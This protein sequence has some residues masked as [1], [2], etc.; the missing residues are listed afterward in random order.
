MTTKI[1]AMSDKIDLE[2]FIDTRFAV[3]AGAN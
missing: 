1:E 3:T 2:S